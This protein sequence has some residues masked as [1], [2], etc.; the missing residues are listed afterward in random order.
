MSEL[1]ISRHEDTR[2]AY[3]FRFNKEIPGIPHEPQEQPSA[4]KHEIKAIIKKYRKQATSIEN[5]AEELSWDGSTIQAPALRKQKGLGLLKTYM[6]E[7]NQDLS[8]LL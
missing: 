1:Y 7:R 8:D 6:M 4:M 3:D 2:G 5:R